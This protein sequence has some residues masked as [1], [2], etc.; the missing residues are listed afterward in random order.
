MPTGYRQHAIGKNRQNGD[1]NRQNRETSARKS[2]TRT[3]DTRRTKKNTPQLQ[4]ADMDGSL[5]ELYHAHKNREKNAG[6][7]YFQPFFC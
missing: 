2:A 7:E 5:Q 6:N 3:E 1:S 4:H